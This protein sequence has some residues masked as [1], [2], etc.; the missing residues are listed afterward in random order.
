MSKDC[1]YSPE[2]P[3]VHV[4]ASTLS[5]ITDFGWS[6][7]K[8]ESLR[9]VVRFL[10][11]KKMMRVDALDNECSAALQF[12]WYFGEN[13]PAF[14]ECIR[15]LSWLPGDVYI[16]IVTESAAVLTE[17]D[18][19]EFSIFISLLDKAGREWSQPVE[20]SEWWRRPAVPFHVIF[21]C[22]ELDKEMVLARLRLVR[23]SQM[24]L[25]SAT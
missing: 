23:A 5:E 10:R 17:E 24:D 13:W 11:G 20:T 21:Q 15:D 6:L 1:L 22:D 3:W 16:V 2:G 9:V 18:E 14:D 8:H 12:P 25:Q 19:K 7:T 4:V